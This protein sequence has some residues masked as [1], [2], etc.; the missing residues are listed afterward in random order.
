MNPAAPVT[1]NLDMLRITHLE[2]VI[3]LRQ[4]TPGAAGRPNGPQ[5]I[6]SGSRRNGGT[7]ERSSP[8]AF[9]QHRSTE[10]IPPG[11]P[12]S[13]KTPAR[14][15]SVAFERPTPSKESVKCQ[16]IEES[17]G[18]V[19]TATPGHPGHVA[20]ERKSARE[21]ARNRAKRRQTEHAN[22]N[23]RQRR[24]RA[25]GHGDRG[26]E[27]DQQDPGSPRAGALPAQ[28]ARDP[29]KPD[30]LGGD[31]LAA[32]RPTYDRRALP[33]CPGQGGTVRLPRLRSSLRQSGRLLSSIRS[34]CRTSCRRSRFRCCPATAT[35]WSICKRCSSAATT[36]ARTGDASGTARPNPFP[37]WMPSGRHGWSDCSTVL[38]EFVET[39]GQ[40]PPSSGRCAG[41]MNGTK[42]RW[43]V[44]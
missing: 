44:R 21:K 6:P 37:P 41:Q 22:R 34:V 43:L 31:R 2:A 25:R 9:R 7:R 29:R 18:P 10:T 26:A 33:P 5:C 27:P 12:H 16:R 30:S 14:A 15:N 23:L 42:T 8:L 36:Q 35:W 40:V 39:I 1:K 4:R 28:T 20:T 17:A 11:G 19:G 32:R 3:P 24:N 13:A 38:A